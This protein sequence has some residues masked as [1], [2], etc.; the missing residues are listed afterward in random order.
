MRFLV[1]L[2]SMGAA[3]TLIAAS[4]L[5]NWV[6]MTSLGRSEFE[7][8]ILGAVSLAVSA[9]IALLPTLLLWAWREGRTLYMA[10]GLPVF[11]AFAAFSLSSAIGFAALNRGSLDENR[12]LATARLGQVKRMIEATASS[13]KDL[14]AVRTVPVVREVLRGL[15][16][17]RRWQWSKSCEAATADASRAFCKDYFDVK[18]EMAKAGEREHLAQHLGELL[19]ERSR[20]E[21]LGAGREAD[22]QAAVLAQLLGLTTGKVERV[23][24]LFLAVLVELGAALGIYFATGHIRAEP[25]RY[26]HPGRGPV[27]IEGNVV[28]FGHRDQVAPGPLKQIAGSGG[29]QAPRRVPRLRQS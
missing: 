21:D 25:R 17:D 22:S 12:A 18:A 16:Q 2:V 10:L 15:E 14:E 6:F 26:G 7:Q 9:F 1:V 11:I 27:I 19:G 20:L 24:T 8:H 29:Q 28:E 3:L 23:L 4:G 5:M 13:L